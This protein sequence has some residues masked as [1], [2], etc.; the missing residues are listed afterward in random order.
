MLHKRR[1]IKQK[2]NETKRNKTKQNKTKQNVFR[3]EGDMGGG[4]ASSR[5]LIIHNMDTYPCPIETDGRECRALSC[6]RDAAAVLCVGSGV[7][8]LSEPD[9]RRTEW[10]A[11]RT[12][13][14][15]LV[16]FS[17]AHPYLLLPADNL[18]LLFCRLGTQWLD[19]DA[20]MHT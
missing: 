10:R 12:A 14:V 6:L 3:A 11:A 17:C 5:S 1:K 7:I 4:E 20:F 15:C 19:A 8:N 2:R 13:V 16:V 9:E 18:V